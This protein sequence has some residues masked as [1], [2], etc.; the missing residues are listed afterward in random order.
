MTLCILVQQL[1]L[2]KKVDICTIVRKLRTQRPQF[3]NTYVS[4]AIPLDQKDDTQKSHRHLHDDF[5]IILFLY[6][7]GTI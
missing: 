2:E 6:I 5:N 3:L 4:F 7:S 1:R